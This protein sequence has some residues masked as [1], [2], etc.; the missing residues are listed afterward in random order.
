MAT[1]PSTTPDPGPRPDSSTQRTE[2]V[3]D[4]NRRRVFDELMRLQ[5][6]TWDTPTSWGG[7]DQ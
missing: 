5:R 7:D 2:P 3:Q 1:A 4:V 6:R